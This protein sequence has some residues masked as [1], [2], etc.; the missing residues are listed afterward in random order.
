MADIEHGGIVAS[1]VMR[2]TN[3]QVAVLNGHGPASK[4][5][6]LA[7]ILNMVVMENSLLQSLVDRK[8]YQDELDRTLSLAYP[9]I[10]PWSSAVRRILLPHAPTSSVCKSFNFSQASTSPLPP[11]LGRDSEPESVLRR[12]PLPESHW[13]ACTSDSVVLDGSLVCKHTKGRG[14]TSPVA[15]AE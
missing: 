3:A 14:L 2:S 5:N 1:P 12:H 11:A 8:V 6:H 13:H 7:S 15:A 9:S 4:G 10:F